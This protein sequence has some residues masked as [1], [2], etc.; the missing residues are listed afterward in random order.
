MDTKHRGCPL[1]ITVTSKAMQLGVPVRYRTKLQGIVLCVAHRE[2][3]R[4]PFRGRFDQR[5]PDAE[6][7]LRWCIAAL[8]LLQGRLVLVQ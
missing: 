5:Y 6:L 7:G 4:R 3:R 8:D 2:E 1:N